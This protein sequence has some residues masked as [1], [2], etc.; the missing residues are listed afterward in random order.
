MLSCRSMA[1]KQ[2]NGILELDTI[3]R[4]KP[5]PDEVLVM[6]YFTGISRYDVQKINNDWNNTT[7][8]LVPGME[9][10]GIVNTL[11]KNVTT[12]KELD[13][14]IIGN[15]INTCG[16]CSF[17]KNKEFNKC[18][19][20]LIKTYDDVDKYSNL[21][22]YLKFTN[23]GFSQ[24]ITVNQNFV[25]KV[26]D[27]KIGLELTRIVPLASSGLAVYSPLKKYFNIGDKV[28]VLGLGGLGHL[29]VKLVI[30]MGGDVN[31]IS[32]S[33]WKRNLAL[34]DL[35]ANS[36]INS[37]NTED[38]EREYNTYDLIIDTLPVDHDISKYINMLKDNG[39]LVLLG[40]PK[41]DTLIK[42]SIFDLKRR[43]IIRSYL[44]SIEELKELITY[45]IDKKIYADIETVNFDSVD[46]AL[47][48][49]SNNKAKFKYVF[50]VTSL[51]L[52]PEE[53]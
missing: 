23:G 43:E 40:L 50:D 16:N 9:L 14:V 20:G 42:N 38:I 21:P 17:C 26:P 37:S 39:K 33:E 46:T 44:G 15:Y 53:I 36:F 48:N 8:P 41:E 45:C 5:G 22:D 27:T 18:S 13:L 31:V 10:L 30:E 28:G 25:V 47:E 35:L 29:A 24:I 6:I 3:I 52:I 32:S 7:Y 2:K 34:F 49:I 19:N 11:G 4:S 12:V 1:I 51:Q